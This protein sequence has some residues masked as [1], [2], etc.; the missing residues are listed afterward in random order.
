MKH[1]P[2]PV[3]I[4]GSLKG[5]PLQRKASNE[6]NPGSRSLV[7]SFANETNRIKNHQVGSLFP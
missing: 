1:S 2:R 4:Q 5:P 3:E 7:Y 6:Q